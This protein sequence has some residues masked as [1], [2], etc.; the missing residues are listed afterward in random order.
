MTGL[1]AGR[2]A[3]VMEQNA[4]T[5]DKDID[6]KYIGCKA[7]YRD[8]VVAATNLITVQSGGCELTVTNN[9]NRT[10]E[11]VFVYYKALHS[12]GNYFGGITYLVEFGTLEPGCSAQNTAGHYQQGSTEIVRIGWQESQS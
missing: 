1:P 12:D 6:P 11:N 4:M 10:L 9:S 8:G 5:V 7:S 3:W 2:S